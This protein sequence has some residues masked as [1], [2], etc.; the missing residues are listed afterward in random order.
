[1]AGRGRGG[2][3]GS[4]R[5]VT[6]AHTRVRAYTRQQTHARECGQFYTTKLDIKKVDPE[7]IKKAE[8]LAR[9]IERERA[10]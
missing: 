4:E 7:K 5:H 9:E 3:L 8:Q 10:R 1:M 2:G 6:H